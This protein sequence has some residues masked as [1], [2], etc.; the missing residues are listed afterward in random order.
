MHDKYRAEEEAHNPSR[1]IVLI[2][3][4]SNTCANAFT[5]G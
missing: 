5:L 3:E 2:E 1:K 4:F